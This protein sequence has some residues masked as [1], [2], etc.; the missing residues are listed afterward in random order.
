MNNVTVYELASEH[1]SS[2]VGKTGAMTDWAKVGANENPYLKSSHPLAYKA[3]EDTFESF[4]E[5][6]GSILA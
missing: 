3:Y 1:D 5:M 4:I 2:I 6:E